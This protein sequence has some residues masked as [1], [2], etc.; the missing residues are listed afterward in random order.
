MGYVVAS[1]N[2]GFTAQNIRENA[3][4]FS[5]HKNINRKKR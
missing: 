3:S 1:G 4:D 2:A 5:K